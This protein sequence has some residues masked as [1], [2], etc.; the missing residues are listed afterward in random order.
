M[1]ELQAILADTAARL[2]E[3][4]L[5]RAARERAE[6]E[7]W[8]PGLWAE[9]EGAGFPFILVDEARGGAGA[10]WEEAAI[11]LRAVGRHAVPLPLAET[12][13]AA[14][15]LDRA[16]IRPPEGPLALAPGEL[17]IS[18]DEATALSAFAGVAYAP[19]CPH[20]VAIA[21]ADGGVRVALFEAGAISEP[22][23]SIAREPRATLSAAGPALAHG[24]AALP[25]DSLQLLVAFARAASIGG[26][27]EA[28]LEQAVR[29]AGE[30][31]QFGRP[32]GR[33]QAVQHQLAQLASA[34]AS[35][36][37]AVDTAARALAR[38]PAAATFDIAVAKLRASD[39]AGAGA[40]I[41]HQTHGAIG[42]TYEHGLHFWTRRLWAWEQEH[43]GAALW[44]ARL[45]REALA[46]GG[47]ALWPAITAR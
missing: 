5:D 1:N 38:D 28:V 18:G 42:F 47:A 7:G 22:T 14:W 35:V 4:H 3:D 15:L 33:F 32:I 44:A 21:P 29:Y 30:R 37:V 17:S 41:A 2:F 23:R 6:E 16:G 12:I 25:V 8:L 34:T 46:A 19:R 24:M 45:G 43:G 10:S 9:V 39:A 40:A 20:I 27:L 31:V 36:G 11:L 26:A 13:L